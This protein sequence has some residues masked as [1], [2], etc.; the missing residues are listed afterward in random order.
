[1]IFAAAFVALIV[2]VAARLVRGFRHGWDR[3]EGA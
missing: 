3:R 2:I 1:M